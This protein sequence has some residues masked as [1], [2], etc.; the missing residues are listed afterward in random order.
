M[1]KMGKRQLPACVILCA[2]LA[3]VL[4]ACSD[5]ALF[6]LIKSKSKAQ[7][8]ARQSLVIFPFDN[9]LDAS[10]NVPDDFGQS[11]AEY[12]RTTLATSR[13]YAVL[14]YDDRLMPVQRARTDNVVKDQ[15]VKSPFCADKA[16]ADKLA[17]ILA[18]DYYLVG[19]VESYTY[20]KD[21]KTVDLALKADLVLAKTGKL[22]QEFMVGGSASAGTQAM[23]EDELCSVAA[24]KAVEAL[25]EKIL[26]TS[27][28]DVKAVAQPPK[29]K[30]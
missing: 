2:M 30:K 22:I 28:A 24:G 6:G 27:A 3:L 25:G 17:D 10:A 18:T 8:V 13:G 16:K 12:L 15:D 19:S 14:L 9:D 1:L 4:A 11:V 7:A 29:A 20:D 21:K 26:S 5:A 23:D